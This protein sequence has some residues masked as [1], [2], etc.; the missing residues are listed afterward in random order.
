MRHVLDKP[1]LVGS[2]MTMFRARRQ[3]NGG[4]IPTWRR[5]KK[6]KQTVKSVKLINF[7]AIL[8]EFKLENVANDS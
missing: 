8:P 3:L 7:E 2:R 5:K 4:R 1:G 6:S